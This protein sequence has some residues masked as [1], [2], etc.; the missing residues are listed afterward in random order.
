MSGFRLQD[1]STKATAMK[2][3]RSSYP[4]TAKCCCPGSEFF[5]RTAKKIC[6]PSCRNSWRPGSGC[7]STRCHKSGPSVRFFANR[8]SG[9]TRKK[10]GIG[11]RPRIVRDWKPRRD[12]VS[13]A[14]R[15]LGWAKDNLNWW[16]TRPAV[17]SI[18]TQYSFLNLRHFLLE[19]GICSPCSWLGNR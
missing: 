12:R 3:S 18:R 5:F 14:C 17:R 10:F 16:K 8:S 4:W 19:F 1:R 2:A 13:S 11:T 7:P 9:W 15:D 6:L